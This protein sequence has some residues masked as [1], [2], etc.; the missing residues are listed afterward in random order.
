[1]KHV[2]LVSYSTT[3]GPGGWLQLDGDYS[4]LDQVQANADLDRSKENEFVDLVFHPDDGDFVVPRTDNFP[5]E[6]VEAMAEDD[7][8]HIIQV[9]Y[10]L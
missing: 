6:I 3:E 1:M 4:H 5:T 9:Y 2:T 10:H 8:L 7:V